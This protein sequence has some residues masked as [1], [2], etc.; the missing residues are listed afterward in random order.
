MEAKD[1]RTLSYIL[2]NAVFLIANIPK[3]AIFSLSRNAW[4]YTRLEK[5]LVTQCISQAALA[6]DLSEVPLS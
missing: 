6:F 2:E 5:Q 1:A 3:F 4:V